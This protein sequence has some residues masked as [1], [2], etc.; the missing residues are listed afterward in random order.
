MDSILASRSIVFTKIIGKLENLSYFSLSKLV[1]HSFWNT[2]GNVGRKV[3]VRRGVCVS[4][5]QVRRL[6]T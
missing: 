6:M 2:I 3:R 4:Q 5:R 1:S